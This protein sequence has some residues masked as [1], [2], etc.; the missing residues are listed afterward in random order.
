MSCWLGCCCGWAAGGFGWLNNRG[1]RVRPPVIV[2]RKAGKGLL[3]GLVW[4]TEKYLEGMGR[5]GNLR[6]IWMIGF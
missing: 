4:A 2:V 3:C 1:S 5:V 6:M